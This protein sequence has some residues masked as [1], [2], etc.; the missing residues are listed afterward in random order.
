MSK[1]NHIC[2]LCGKEVVANN[3]FWRE[4][5]L[6][7]SEYYIA[8][9]PRFSKQTGEPIRFKNRDFYL[10]SDFNDKREMKA[11]FKAHPE[12]AKTY[13]VEILN[14]RKQQKDLKYA[15][16]QVE[17]HSLG[18]PHIAWYET[19]FNQRYSGVCKELGLK[20]RFKY[21]K[22]WPNQQERNWKEE[23]ILIDTR[24]QVPL[25]FRNVKTQS[26]KLDYGDYAIKNC[27][28]HI[29]RKSLSDFVNTLGTGFD[30][31]CREIDRAKKKKAYLVVLVE[32]NIANALVF[33]YLPHM[34]F[35]TKSTP[36]Y[37]F[38][39]VRKLM[40]KYNNIQFA[41]ADGRIEASRIAKRIFDY[42][43]KSKKIDFQYLIDKKIL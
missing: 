13:A 3:H 28:V 7:E 11:W 37:V 14:R 2:K 8:N 38:H 23:C 24:E 1:Q 22:D 42:G 29:E 19:N 41:F 10:N 31:F 21:N 16:S 12:E 30:R 25:N 18:L 27:D 32:S 6:K 9:I 15:L 33:N 34:K 39:N 17:M 43:D 36:D 40:Q 26:I 20:P 5:K 4:H 35:A